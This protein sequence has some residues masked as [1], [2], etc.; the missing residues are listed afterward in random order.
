MDVKLHR[1]G[2]ARFNN[3]ARAA[4]SGGGTFADCPVACAGGVGYGRAMGCFSVTR[5]AV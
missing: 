5:T 2:A 3:H 1:L 4:F